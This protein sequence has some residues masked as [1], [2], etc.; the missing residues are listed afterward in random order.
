[1]T[2]SQLI[3]PI[4]IKKNSDLFVMQPNDN[5]VSISWHTQN[6]KYCCMLCLPAFY[7]YVLTRINMKTFFIE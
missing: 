6:S 3:F 1:M 7:I 4:V 5:N 2:Y